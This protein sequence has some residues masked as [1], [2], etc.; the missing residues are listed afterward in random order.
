MGTRADFYV[1]KENQMTWLGSIGWDGYPDG[2]NS[3]V[4]EATTEEEFKEKINAF[5]SERDD[6]SLPAN[7][8]PW[9]WNDSS[10]TDYAYIFENNKVMGSCFGAGVFDPLKNEDDEGELPEFPNMS[11]LKNVAFGKKSGLIVIGG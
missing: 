4:F 11:N 3:E 1:K 6:V 7:G 9:P 10:T 2:I 8:W 5:F